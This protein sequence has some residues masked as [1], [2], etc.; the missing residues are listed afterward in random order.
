MEQVRHSLYELLFPNGK[1]YLGITSNFSKRMAEHSR[2]A[3]LEKKRP[4][5]KA[6]RRFGWGNVGKKVL[7]VGPK[8][9]IADLE[10]KAITAFNSREHGYNV[11]LGGDLSPMLVPET[12]KKQSATLTG[13]KH[14]D[15]SKKS[16][17]IA[18]QGRKHT[19]E[20]K[21]QI[22]AVHR[23]KIVSFEQREKQRLAMTG[24]MASDETRAKMSAVRTGSKR[25]EETKQKMRDAWA[26]R[27]SAIQLS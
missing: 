27:K 20:T 9:Y 25:S 16:M 26:R 22:G 19:P 21:E 14:T 6:I 13:Y 23:G 5:Y 15:E 11:S 12:R 2:L 4:V 18:Q 24:R 7:A 8:D 17:S 1:R 10:I 3:R